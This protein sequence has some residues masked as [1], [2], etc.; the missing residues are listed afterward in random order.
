MFKTFQSG[1]S[2]TR[3]SRN[4]LQGHTLDYL[5]DGVTNSIAK[6]DQMIRPDFQKDW[7]L[8]LKGDPRFAMYNKETIKHHLDKR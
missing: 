6:R 2:G 8:D 3:G 5:N 4:T 1:F 7:L